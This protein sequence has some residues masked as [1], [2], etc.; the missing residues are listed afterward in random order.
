MNWARAW[1]RPPQ[2]CEAD[3]GCGWSERQKQTVARFLAYA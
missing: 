3:M 2:E 1:S